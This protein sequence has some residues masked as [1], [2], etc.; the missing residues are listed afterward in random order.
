MHNLHDPLLLLDSHPWPR[1]KWKQHTKAVVTSYHEATLRHPAARNSKLQYLN[2][3]TNGL[4]GRPHPILSWVQTTQD[5]ALVRPHVKM[6]G[7]DYLCFATLAHDRG[8]E[9]YCGL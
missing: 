9:P 2:V 8:L 5:V 7:G 1:E 3:Q 6:L 4:S